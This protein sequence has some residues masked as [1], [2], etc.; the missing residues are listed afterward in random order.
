M[1][2]E[3]VLYYPK[4]DLTLVQ[5]H[6]YA[7]L[8][9]ELQV[10]GYDYLEKEW[11]HTFDQVNKEYEPTIRVYEDGKMTDFTVEYFNT[12]DKIK[13]GYFKDVSV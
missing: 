1:T 6:D 5:S 12:L 11:G 7:K 8:Q 10:R 2:A 13:E 3:Y 4:E 9:H